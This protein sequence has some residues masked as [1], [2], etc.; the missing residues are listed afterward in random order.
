MCLFADRL[1]SDEMK[2]NQLRLYFSALAYTL[3]EALRRLGLKGTEWAQA[4]AH[5]IR[6]KLLKIGAI[7]RVSVRRV[8]LQLSSAY[9][10]KDLYARAYH[11]LRC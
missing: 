4:Q 11:A 6:R 3:M 5:T 1:S 2:A 10:W 9:P 7:V 8:L